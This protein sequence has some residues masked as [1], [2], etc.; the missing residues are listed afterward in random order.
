MW[1]FIGCP[2]I[3][4]LILLFLSFF[5][6]LLRWHY[7]PKRTFSPL[8]D[9]FH[10]VLLFDHSF[11]FLIFH[12]F[13]SVCTQFNHLFLGRLLSRL[14]WGLSSNTWDTF[15][16]LSILLTWPIQFNRFILT[17]YVISKPPNS[18]INSSFYSLLQI[19]FNLIPPNI[20][21]KTFL[22][23]A[24]SSLEIS[25]CNNQDSAQYV[26]TGLTDILEISIVLS[27]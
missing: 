12:L 4:L 1:R 6:L 13:I 23:K 17:N 7:S 27:E 9:F 21:L 16:L 3:Y 14:P 2:Q 26:V 20:L 24:D 19:S 25:L 15:L 18:C 10:S 11:Q 8:M 22:S 5:L